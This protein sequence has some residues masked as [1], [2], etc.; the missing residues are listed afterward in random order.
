MSV[1]APPVARRPSARLSDKMSRVLR[2]AV[3]VIVILTLVCG[4]ARRAAGQSSNSVA[5]ESLFQEAR[6][7]LAAG[8][9]TEACEKLASSEEIDP[10]VGT[11]LNLARCYE[12]I[13]RTASAWAIYRKAITAAKQ[14]GQGE[15]ERAARRAA[16]SLEP[17]LSRLTVNVPA[18]LSPAK[19]QVVRDG[20]AMP[21][22]LWGAVVPV[23][24]GEH[25]ISVTAV[26]KK[27]WSASVVVAPGASQQVNVTSLQPVEPESAPAE[28]SP[29]K[30]APVEPESVQ[31]APG[32]AEAPAR[33]SFWNSQKSVATVVSA[34]AV[35]GIVVGAVE[36]VGYLNKKDQADSICPG[37][38][39]EQ[40]PYNQAVSLLDDA[41]SARTIAI[42]SG[43]VGAAALVGAAVL[44][45]AS[46]D[47]SAPT[48]ATALVPFASARGAG[49]RWLVD[50]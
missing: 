50:F 2:A 42:V 12:K 18:D 14:A 19:V 38:R 17:R 15:R 5:A 26:D 39:C 34:I 8:R 16:E 27:P 9:Y 20:E 25:K 32:P 48:A 47:G 11:L 45:F 29:I 46:G 28:V 40:G 35:A 33:H 44:W 4:G 30:R 22:E 10:A 1:D 6:K 7:L 49:L 23:D 13:G 21:P 37:N 43:S 31:A 36:T 41:R 24:P 3:G